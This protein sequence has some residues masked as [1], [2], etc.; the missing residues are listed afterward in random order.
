MVDLKLAQA[1]A[2]PTSVKDVGHIHPGTNFDGF[3]DQGIVRRLVTMCNL[4][5]DLHEAGAAVVGYQLDEPDQLVL[6][7]GANELA[8]IEECDVDLS[9]DFQVL[10]I[11]P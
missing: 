11:M 9:Q 4:G 3:G 5:D 1:P 8:S 2:A 7:I 10:F 6:K